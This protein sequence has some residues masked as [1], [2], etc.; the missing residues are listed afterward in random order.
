M[1]PDFERLIGR[2]AL[3]PAFRKRLLDDPDAAA[4]EAGLQ[5]DPAEMDRLRK[6]LADPVQ[7]GVDGRNLGVGA[8][9]VQP[10]HARRNAL[11]AFREFVMTSIEHAVDAAAEAGK[12]LRMQ[13][14]PVPCEKM[15]IEK[16]DHDPRV[17][18][19]RGA[20]ARF[21][22][23]HRRVRIGKHVRSAVQ[24]DRARDRL[25][26]TVVQRALDEVA[27][28]TAEKRVLVR[29]RKIEMTE[30]I[31]CDFSFEASSP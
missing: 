29:R 30:I 31:Q 22:R 4:K 18:P 9:P 21:R 19:A 23:A 6:A 16:I 13:A 17:A 28:Q 15:I 25:G 1:S 14:C 24:S 26:I 10:R 7:R 8:E 3:D 11:Q 20:D 27:Q 12:R 5:P 2:A